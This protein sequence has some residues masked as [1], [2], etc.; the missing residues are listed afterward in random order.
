MV[1]A[2]TVTT[3][4]RCGST[5]LEALQWMLGLLTVCSSVLVERNQTRSGFVT[6]WV[7]KATTMRCSSMTAR[8][9]D[10]NWC[11]GHRFE[12]QVATRGGTTIS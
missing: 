3:F 4:H 5:G 1:G 10:G 9:N 7:A 2:A 12:G 11:I 6:E 8:T